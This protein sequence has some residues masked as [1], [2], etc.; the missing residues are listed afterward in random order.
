[1]WLREGEG[2]CPSTPPGALPL[3]PTKG[4][5]LETPDFFAFGER[6]RLGLAC[7]PEWPLSPKA[8][9]ALR[10]QGARPLGGVQGRSPCR[11]QGRAQAFL[12]PHHR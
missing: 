5:A 2:R 3:D 8:N 4:G 12:E 6:G 1:M 10:V 9:Y 11:V 7:R